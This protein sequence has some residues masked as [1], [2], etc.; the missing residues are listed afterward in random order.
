MDEILKTKTINLTPAQ[1]KVLKYIF[2]NLSDAVFMTASTL[3]RKTDVSEATI[4]RLSQALDFDGFPAFQKYL[5]QLHNE[6]L[7]TVRRLEKRLD[8]S[9][10]SNPLVSA[11]QMD[12]KNMSTMAESIS[13]KKFDQVVN[14]LWKAKKIK[15]IGLRSAFSMA[16]YLKFGLQ[17][18]GRQVSLIQPTHGD[19]W[20]H[21]AFLSKD[22]LLVAISFPRYSSLTVDIVAL[23]KQKKCRIVALTDSLVSPLTHYSDWILTA[24]CQSDSYMDSF[25]APMGLLHALLTS[26]SLKKPDTAMNAFRNLETIWNKHKIYFSPE[27][28]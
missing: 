22:D 28:Q 9:D 4:I 16:V 10:T 23:A 19:L 24:P 2:N 5:R 7:T 18:L 8:L 13:E 20:D 6:R 3:G 27:G 25:T 26:M 21:L 17:Y 15:I 14:R 11:I 1:Q 12:I